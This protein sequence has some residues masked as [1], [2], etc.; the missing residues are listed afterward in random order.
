[1]NRYREGGGGRSYGQD[2]ATAAGQ[3]NTCRNTPL[4]H[5]PTPT[6]THPPTHS[7][8]RSEEVTVVVGHAKEPPLRH[9]FFPPWYPT[10]TWVSKHA[11]VT[12]ALQRSHLWCGMSGMKKSGW[13]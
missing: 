1:M 2:A 6:G 3:R 11:L 10:H 12:C 4:P 9:S 7:H 13:G 5:T 8:L